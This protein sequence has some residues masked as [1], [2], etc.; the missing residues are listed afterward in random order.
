LPVNLPHP[1]LEIVLRD[2][3][4]DSIIHAAGMA[5]VMYS[6][7]N[8]LDDF[9]ASTQLFFYL[10]D[11]VRRVAPDSKIVF[12]SS[13]AVYGNPQSLPV[14]EEQEIQPVSPYGYHKALCEKIVEEFVNLYHLHACSVRIF[15]AYGPGL[16]KQIFW[17]ICEKIQSAPQISLM[18]T[19]KETRDFIYIDDIASAINVICKKS[20]FEADVYNLGNGEEISVGYIAN[21]L[22]KVC[23]SSK[24]IHFSGQHR[25]GDPLH[26]CADNSK[27]RNLGYAPKISFDK[28]VNNYVKWFLEEIT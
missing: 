18:G 14:K 4:P 16:R 5:S 25:D 3:Q 23:R 19:G 12:L 24:D 22:R 21:L 10:L 7:M 27:I 20:S 17:D 13:A 9:L 26:W 2:F 11:T 15:S 6:V 28:G 8:P 1:D